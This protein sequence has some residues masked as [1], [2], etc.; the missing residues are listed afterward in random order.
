MP[1]LVRHYVAPLPKDHD[2]WGHLPVMDNPH[3]WRLG[4]RV[5]DEPG[6]EEEFRSGRQVEK[7]RPSDSTE[8]D[9]KDGCGPCLSFLYF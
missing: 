1:C 8:G 6:L 5:C 3:V 9:K 4:A 2:F 7:S